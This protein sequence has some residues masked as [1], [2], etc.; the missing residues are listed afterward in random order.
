MSLFRRQAVEHAARPLSGQ[1]IVATP[2][3]AR[4]VGLVLAGIV[5]LALIVL[6]FASY[7]RKETVTGWLVPSGGLIRVTAGVGGILTDV[8]VA[9]G[10]LV[11]QGEPVATIGSMSTLPGTNADDV[12][13][14]SQEAERLASTAS[15]DARL[16]QIRGQAEELRDR[17]QVILAEM[18]AIEARAA[19]TRNRAEVARSQL[20]RGEELAERGFLSRS[21][22]DALRMG[23]LAAEQEVEDGKL[24]MLNYRRQ[25][26]DLDNQI[27]QA[28]PEMAAI[29]AS[30]AQ[31]EAALRGDEVS[32]RN[33]GSTV[34]A[35]PVAG[36]VLALPMKKGQPVTA[37]RTVA[38][39]APKESELLA[40][41]FIPTRAAGFVRPGQEVRLLFQ[42]YPY[43]T[44]G[45]G[46]GTVE[47]ISRT[48][49]APDDIPVPGMNAVEPMFRVTVRMERA[50][51][52][53][54][55]ERRPLEAG[56]LLNADIITDRRSLI[57][58]LLDPLYA[59]GRR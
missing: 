5:A 16:D 54:Y 9:E 50:F 17:R 30:A 6:S 7:S 10:G 4:T 33:L 29:R 45:T 40:E 21:N 55:G 24:A 57:R 39:L 8:G 36:R 41:L 13:R 15:A 52:E 22:L 28:G 14:E 59:V 49:F 20:A 26:S 27:A 18:G 23:T 11:A 2:M 35:A 46:R 34:L 12:F 32:S 58:W 42:A 48:A 51:V 3:S 1:V 38:I 31:A 19:L 56:M 43:Q 47:A 53:A 44:F 37:G 25:I